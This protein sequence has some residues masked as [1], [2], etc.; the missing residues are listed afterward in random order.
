VAGRGAGVTFSEA[1]RA[2]RSIR[3][4][5]GQQL[6]SSSTAYAVYAWSLL[7]VI[8]LAPILRVLIIGLSEE[9]ALEA[10]LSPSAATVL[11]TAAGA[12][13]A[14]LLVLGG[15]RGP[16][17]PSP[18]LTYTLVGSSFPRRQTLRA[19]QLRASVLSSL[20]VI[21][22]GLLLG[23]VLLA[24][25][26]ID[27]TSLLLLLAGMGAFGLI[28]ATVWLA[29]QVLSESATYVLALTIGLATTMSA[30]FADLRVAFPWG[31]LSAVYP[32]AGG[33]GQIW[34]AVALALACMLAYW[35][36]PW[37]L[38][39]LNMYSVLAQS[40]RWQTFTGLAT[41]GDLGTALGQWRSM[42][43]VGRR[44]RAIR[45][46][47]PIATFL[48]RDLVGSLRSPI[49]FVSAVVGLI[50]FALLIG[51][52]FHSLPELRWLFIVA[53]GVCGYLALGVWADG[54]RYAVEAS[55]GPPLLGQRSLRLFALHSALPT[56]A[57]VT[58]IP[59]SLLIAGVPFGSGALLLAISLGIFL[60]TL[61]ML[62]TAKGPLPLSLL[63]PVSTPAGDLSGLLIIYWQADAVAAAAAVSA[64]LSYAFFAVGPW[65]VIG[66]IPA[67]AIALWLTR[68]RLSMG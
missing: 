31:W 30:F 5:R 7:L 4:Q 17:V 26:A 20:A 34:A 10:L 41:F 42:P 54:F 59:T 33:D 3:A 61:R 28:A 25:R 43:R 57:L 21:A 11:Q 66:L 24:S 19:T 8:V 40:Q 39:R 12:F 2:I 45:G 18:Y 52:A 16:A 22:I 36:T 68:R 44:W 56:V 15:T 23:G 46:S 65:T 64:G 35:S 13:L 67:G 9:Q 14:L 50:A 49:R 55:A 29:G 1:T 60:L 27:F 53:G 63:A 38:E 62:D 48:W 6:D 32:S 51:V 58:L 47:L 37:L